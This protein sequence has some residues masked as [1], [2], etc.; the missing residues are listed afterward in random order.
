MKKKISREK[1]VLEILTEIYIFSIVILFPIAV[2]ST[3]FFHIFEFKWNL[4]TIITTIYLA[5]TSI[6]SLYYLIFKSANI[7]KEIKLGMIHK[8]AIVFLFI[9]VISCFFSPFFSDYD[10]LTGVGRK[11]GLI[12]TSLYV[13]SFLY[14]S[15]FGKFKRRY[16]TYFAISSLL[17]NTVA[18]LQYV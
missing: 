5:I 9:N 16:I 14:V 4:Y 17:V 10:L 13:L 6:L 15:L 12:L 7:F 3:G 11:E 8:C 2:D 18:F 1:K